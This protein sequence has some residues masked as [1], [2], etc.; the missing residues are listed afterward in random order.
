MHPPNTRLRQSHKGV[1]RDLCS[2]IANKN[3]AAR[4]AAN[5]TLSAPDRRFP[6]GSNKPSRVQRLLVAALIASAAAALLL[7]SYYKQADFKADFSVAWFGASAILNDANPYALVGP[8]RVYD[9]EWTLLYPVTALI[10][11]IPLTLLSEQRAAI[12]FIWVSTFLLV[13]GTTAKSWHLLPVFVSEAFAASARLGQWSIIMTAMLFIPVLAVFA[14]VK[15]Q[16]SLPIIASTRS[17]TALGAALAGAVVLTVVSFVLSPEWP[18][19][20]LASVAAAPYMVAPLTRMGGFLI[21]LVILRPRRW[22]A[23]LVLSMACLPQT[24]GWYNTLALLTIAATFREACA[25]VLLSS[26]GAFFCDHFLEGRSV[27]LVGAVMVATAYLPAVVVVLRRPNAGD[28]P[29]WLAL[30]A[31][32]F[33]FPRVVAAPR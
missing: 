8:G 2:G 29:A 26:L 32:P 10:P 5:V 22:E 7:R 6:W 14:I 15:P 9:W 28:L 19:A 1:R 20:W 31:R 12:V 24:W 23:W 27:A 16:A 30:V 33:R 11:V 21:F 17:R 25:L 3:A 13:Y 4:C 18:A